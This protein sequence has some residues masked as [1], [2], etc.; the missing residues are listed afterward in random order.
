MQIRKDMDIKSERAL[1]I[2]ELQQVEDLSLLRAI[3]A[4]LHYGLKSEGRI[5]I[6]QYNRELDEAEAE[7]DRGEFTTHEDLKKQMGEW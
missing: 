2:K 1:L 5:S 3:K 4:M 7:I 6:E